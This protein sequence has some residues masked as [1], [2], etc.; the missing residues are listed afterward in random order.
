[1]K[2]RHT[3]VL[4]ATTL[5]LCACQRNSDDLASRVQ[6]TADKVAAKVQAK[7]EA[8]NAVLADAN[9][10]LGDDDA[11][12][13]LPKAELTPQGDLLIGGKAVPLTP[14]QKALSL[15]YRQQL[16]A[17]AQQGLEVGKQGA[18]LGVRAA[19]EALSGVLN[20][21]ADK[22]GAQVEAQAEQIK[23]EALKICDSLGTAKTAQDAFAAAVPQFKPYATLGQTDIDDCR[24]E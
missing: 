19:S 3:A 14:E 16:M 15:A 21:D 2:S 22:V 8:K 20:G 4:L 11:H 9:I 1:M 13:N 6:H 7:I 12:A 24:K 5:A 23:Q 17:I 18:R 10:H